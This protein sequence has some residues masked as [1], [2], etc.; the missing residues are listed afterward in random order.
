MGMRL[1]GKTAVVTGGSTGIGAAI[2]RAFAAEGAEVVVNY[3]RSRV[4]AEALAAELQALGG[5][6]AY[7]VQADVGEREEVARLVEESIA[8]LGRVDI[9]AN[10]A[11]ADILTGAGAR[12]SDQEK[13][14]EL[15]RIDLLGTMEC[16]WQVAPLMK[17]AGGGVI[18]NISWDLAISGMRGRNPEMFAAVKAGITGFSKCL[19][20]SWAPEV[21][22]NDLAPGWIATTFAQEEMTREYYEGVVVAT[23]LGRFGLP[24][25]V[26]NAAVYL[27]SDE[28]AF[29][30]GQTLKVN[31]GLSS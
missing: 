24:Q 13:L 1:Q 5:K 21:R 3:C 4:R 25:D 16:C 14:A 22:V 23:P 29:I 11:G 27:A 12:L 28:A 30:T 26:A 9:W 19:A 31:G 10:I 2:A 18:L 20:L 7:A 6:A 17:A 15:L 8:R